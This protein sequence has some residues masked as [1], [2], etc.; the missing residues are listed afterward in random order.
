MKPVNVPSLG[1]RYWA[2]LVLA[3]VFGANLG[4]FASHNLHLGHTLGLLPLAVL[5]AAILAGE[6]YA[7]VGTE[8]FYWLALVTLRTAATNLT[9]FADHDLKL[10]PEWVMAALA[11]ALAAL[12]LSDRAPGAPPRPAGTGERGDLPAT[13]TRYWITMLVVGVLGTAMGDY[14]ADDLGLDP[15]PAAVITVTVLASLLLL[16]RW[17]GRCKAA[18]WITGVAVRTAGTNVADFLA[19]HDGLGL[20]L[21]LSTTLTGLA[22]AGTVALWRPQPGLE[23]RRA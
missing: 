11:V 7:R 4:D 5:F 3:S 17:A 13:G 20:G 19:A 18:Y 1:P 14:L 6:R 23:L 21:P 10:S 9:D 2:V 16:R 8:A 15:G 12:I 22:L